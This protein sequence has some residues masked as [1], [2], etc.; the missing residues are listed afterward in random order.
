[1]DFSLNNNESF[2]AFKTR[3]YN[4]IGNGE[5]LNSKNFNALKVVLDGLKV[6][7]VKKKYTSAAYFID[8]PILFYPKYVLK[9][10]KNIKSVLKSFPV[11]DHN[12]E[13]IFFS[14][15]HRIIVQNDNT[16]SY[17]FTKI[18]E[19]LDK[20][21]IVCLFDSVPDNFSQFKCYSYQDLHYLKNFVFSKSAYS[22]K[23]ELLSLFNKIKNLKVFSPDDVQNI[24][25]A[26]QFFFDGVILYSSIL[27]RFPSLKLIVMVQH[28]HNESLIFAAKQRGIPVIELQHGIIST[29]DIF[30]VFPK[31]VSGILHRALFPDEIFVFGN[32][33]KE[34]LL[35]GNEFDAEH[36]HVVGD[37]ILRPLAIENN[38]YQEEIRKFKQDFHLILISTQTFMDSFYIPY[39]INISKLLSEQHTDWKIIVKIHP[40]ENKKTY[41][42]QLY[43]YS[44]VLITDY[45]NL[46]FLFS[47]SDVHIS[48]YSTTLFEAL[49]YNHIKNLTLECEISNDYREEIINNKIAYPIKINDDPL[50]VT[51]DYSLK[52]YHELYSEFDKEKVAHVFNK[53]L[54]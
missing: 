41:T 8:N 21:K 18:S 22:L 36:I 16:Y 30:Y 47:I 15:D 43:L 7:Y 38:L 53:H 14:N 42:D 12:A 33:W 35:E 11:Q 28:Y 4:A 50:T 32:H 1:M 6:N 37:F 48:V 52:P 49:K 10:I 54:N 46:D 26:F 19:C 2:T 40:N 39:I 24:S 31:S 45:S 9:N 17:W 3:F 5:I 25:L 13:V 34:I 27:D 51:F 29:K 23:N 44:N 20:D